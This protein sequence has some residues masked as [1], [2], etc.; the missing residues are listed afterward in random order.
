MRPG[1]QQRS[2]VPAQ[3]VC[4]PEPGPSGPAPGVRG[5]G[6][7]EGTGETVAESEVK[8]TGAGRGGPAGY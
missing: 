4:P 7:P 2:T 6:N 3:A 1:W 5:D 8:G